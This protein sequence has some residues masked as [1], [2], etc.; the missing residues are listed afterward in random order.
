MSDFPFCRIRKA[1][2][3]LVGAGGVT[4]ELAKNLVLSG[5][6]C[7]TLFDDQ[8]FAK[9]DLDSVFFASHS[10]IGRNVSLLSSAQ[11]NK[12]APG[13]LLLLLLLLL[14]IYL[15]IYLLSREQV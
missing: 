3:A 12:K 2:V 14:F 13:V 5:F 1:R 9:S 11:P 15:F 10:D 4:C 7:V 6:G 8:V